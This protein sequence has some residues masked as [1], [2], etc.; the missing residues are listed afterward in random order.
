MQVKSFAKRE[1]LRLIALCGIVLFVFFPL[2][3]LVINIKGKD[4]AFVFSDKNFYSALFTSIRYTFISSVIA[5][6]LALFSAYLLN[7]SSL[8]HKNFYVTVLTFGMLV[9]T[10]SIG[11]GIRV[12]FGTNGFLDSILGIKIEGIGYLGLILGSIIS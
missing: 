7:T 12:M 4:L 6:L 11:L 2:L 3:S 10:L 1:Y 5:T 8:K 9:P